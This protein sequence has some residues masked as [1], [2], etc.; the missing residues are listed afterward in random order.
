MKHR[1][2]IPGATTPTRIEA[3]FDPKFN[4]WM[5]ASSFRRINAD[6]YEA[7]FS[8]TMPPISVRAHYTK[9]TAQHDPSYDAPNRKIKRQVL[10]KMK[11]QQHAKK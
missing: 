6:Q 4:I 9:I 8:T 1:I 2:T 11:A 5:P 10:A 3:M 7:T